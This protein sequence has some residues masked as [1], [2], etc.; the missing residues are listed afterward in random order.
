MNQQNPFDNSGKPRLLIVGASTRAAAFSAVRAG[1]QPV[2]VDQYADQDLR[3]IAE[4]IPKT[5]APAHWIESLYQFPT[6]DWIYTG[7]MENHPDLIEQINQKHRL[8]GCGPESLYRARDP[9]YLERLL[10]DKPIQA[11]PCRPVGFI[12]DDNTRWLHKPLKGAGGMGIRFLDSISPDIVING[13]C[14][15]QRYQPGIPLSALFIAFRQ[16]T[17]LI[18]VCLQLIGNAALNAEAFQFC[19]GMTVSPALAPLRNPLEELGRTVAESCEIQGIFGC[20]L[21]LDPT[22]TDSLWL[23][24]VNPRYTALTELLE[25]QHR[26]PLLDWHLTACR[27]FE[28]HQ[29]DTTTAPKLQKCVER[30]EKQPLP[31]ISKGILY[32]SR[33]SV[34][35]QTVGN[36]LDFRPRYHIPECG[37]IPC[38]G[39][40]IPAGSPVCTIYGVGEN[41]ESCLKSLADRI[42]WFERHFDLQAC[43]DK[44]ASSAFSKL[45]PVKT[46]ENQFFTGFFSSR[47]ESGSFLED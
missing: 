24:E 4:V 14:Y 16:T 30:A 2:C 33:D 32:A 12:P 28:E 9:F 1:W 27:S 31:Y 15:L 8:R 11:V 37:D 45:W 39:T 17:V 34:S 44:T 46:S 40:A 26:T 5:E 19:G 3:E 41:H 29:I 35:S 47:N 18:G 6:L 36:R 21:L 43:Q 38:A 42:A 7:G 10:K 20:D 23:N 22:Q 25:L 13:D